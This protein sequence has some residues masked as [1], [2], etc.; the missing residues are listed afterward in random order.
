MMVLVMVMMMMMIAG[1]RGEEV[2]TKRKKK[3]IYIQHYLPS[4][5]AHNINKS[6]TIILI[7]YRSRKS[8]L[9]PSLRIT[10]RDINAAAIIYFGL[11]R[12]YS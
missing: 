3:H 5:H 10:S 1:G 2:N 8:K 11:Y 7:Q 12:R 6:T 4:R 9:A